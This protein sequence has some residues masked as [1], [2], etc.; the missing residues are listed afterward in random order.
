MSARKL[1]PSE[2]L[3]TLRARLQRN[4]IPEPNTGC[5]VW[6]AAINKVTGYGIIGT[7]RKTMN[8]SRAAFLVW[9]G[10]PE[11]MV[12][13]HA[14]DNRWCVNPSHLS[15]GSPKDNMDDMWR[16][17]RGSAGDRHPS[18][19]L[20]N[21]DVLRVRGLLAAGATQ[22]EVADTFGVTRANIS[23]IATGRSRRRT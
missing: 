19:K 17:A 18:S 15:V 14:C 21:A 13:R 4:S 3:E 16:R 5:W 9:V 22:L 10:D 7:G 20:S 1:G 12:V 6:T 2:R 8:A 11:G 23:A